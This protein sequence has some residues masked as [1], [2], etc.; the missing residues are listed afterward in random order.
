MSL[1]TRPGPRWQTS[2]LPRLGR[3]APCTQKNYKSQHAML[4][5]VLGAR[6]RAPRGILGF[7][8]PNSSPPVA[9]RILTRPSDH[10]EAERPPRHSGAGTQD[11]PQPHCQQHGQGC[12]RRGEDKGATHSNKRRM[13]A[14]RRRR[15]PRSGQS[16]IYGRCGDSNSERARPGGRGLL[17]VGGV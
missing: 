11:Y 10:Q 14:T 1:K 12:P 13:R 8:V 6:R 7:V 17:A 16:S 2:I 5:K 9:A 15:P 4:H 3:P